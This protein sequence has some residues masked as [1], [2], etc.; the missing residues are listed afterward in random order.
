MSIVLKNNTKTEDIKLDRVIEF[1]E[2]SRAYSIG[3]IRKTK[4]LRSYTWRC[5]DWFDQG[6]EGA[7]VGFALG[8]ELAAR[9]A[10]VKGLEANFLKEDVYWEAQK[11]DPWEGGAY[12]GATPVYE[13]TSVLSRVKSIKGNG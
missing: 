9:P 1:D 10:E 7:C 8:H 12:P 2:R 4:K 3:D 11:N 5:T 6:T 13:G